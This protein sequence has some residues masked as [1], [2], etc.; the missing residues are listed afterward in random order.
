MCDLAEIA[1]SHSATSRR[2]GQVEKRKTRRR[3]GAAASEALT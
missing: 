1:T 2:S 3:V